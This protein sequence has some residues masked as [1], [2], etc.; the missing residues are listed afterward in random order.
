[1]KLNNFLKFGLFSLFLVVAV[2]GCVKEWKDAIGA[3][4]EITISRPEETIKGI[5]IGDKVIVPVK[6]TSPSGV[7]R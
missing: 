5:N 6:A 3:G 2:S 7:K 1:M 4:P